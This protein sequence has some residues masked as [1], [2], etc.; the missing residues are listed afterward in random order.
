V[1]R[2]TRVSEV[3]QEA[4]GNNVGA[5]RLKLESIQEMTLIDV[6]PAPLRGR[7]I[8]AAL[9]LKSAGDSPLR[10]VTVGG[11]GAQWFE[12]SGS[13]YAQQA[14]GATF[15]HRR[16][17]DLPWSIARPGGDFCHVIL[18]NGGTS[19]EMADATPPDGDGWQSILINPAGSRRP[20]RGAEPWA[21]GFRR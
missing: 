17:P 7:A 12:G 13:G 9:H 18:G 5:P 19:W 10:R 3:G 20:R 6:D 8:A 4:D 14:G 16:H 11:I 1:T 21:T 15:R 2:D